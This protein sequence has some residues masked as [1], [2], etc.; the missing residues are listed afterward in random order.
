MFVLK[1]KLLFKIWKFPFL[2][3]TFVLEQILTAIHCGYEVRILVEELQDLKENKLEELIE[4]TGMLDK[5]IL[6]NYRIPSSKFLRILKAIYLI[7]LNFFQLNKIIDGLRAFNWDY[8]QIFQY[9]FF[10]Q[11]RDYDIIHVQYGTN[12]KPLDIYKKTGLIKAKLIVSFHGHD[13]FFPINGIIQNNGYYNDLFNYGDLIVANTEYLAKVITELGCEKTKLKTIPVGVDTVYFSPSKKALNKDGIFKII[14]VGRLDK[15]KGQKYAIELVRLLKNKG[16]NLHLTIIGEGRE[17]RNLEKLITKYGLQSE[18]DLMGKKDRKEVKESLNEHDIF[19]L[20]AVAVENG[21]RETQGLAALEAQACG[22]PAVVFNSGGVKYTVMN[23]KT[24]FIVPEYDVEAMGAK[25]EELI[26]DPEL[27]KKMGLCAV[28]FVRKEF[29][30]NQLR[31]VWCDVYSQI[32]R[33][34]R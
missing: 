11:F 25:I 13:A 17:R 30:Q 16:Y 9:N 1:G 27:R 7:G 4:E 2:S 29:S 26:I 23:G 3:E 22:V 28:E 14:S 34:D 10:K 31:K 15:V 32:L 20:P 33:N 12:V 19:V 6:E 8:K 18:V 24:G 5:V 21:R